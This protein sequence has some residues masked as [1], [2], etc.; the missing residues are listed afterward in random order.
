MQLQ[1]IIK[2]L[3]CYAIEMHF[4]LVLPVGYYLITNLY[5]MS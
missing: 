1:I 2:N 4:L 3:L 5:F